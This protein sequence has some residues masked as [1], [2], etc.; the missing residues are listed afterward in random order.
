MSTYTSEPGT[1]LAGRYR[2]VDQVSTGVGWTFWKATDETLARAVT[3]LTFA[4]GFPR[5]TEA[6]TAARAASRLNDSRFAQVFDVEESDELAYVVSEW[7]TGETLVDLLA[8]GP[9]DPP[10]AT[11]IVG[12]AAHAL[13]AA[14]RSGQAHLRLDPSG[15]HWT[16]GGGVKIVGLG[17]DAALAGAELTGAETE[18]PALIDARDLGRLLYAALTG[19]WP[20]PPGTGTGALPPAPTDSDGEPCTPR[21]VTADVPASIDAFTCR[22]LF[23]QQNRQGPPLTSPAEFADALAAVAPRNQ[24]PPA[25]VFGPLTAQASGYRPADSA[26]SPYS[27]T[28]A[29]PRSGTFPGPR[30]QHGAPSAGYRRRH[31]D[32]ERSVVARSVVSAVIVLVLAAV[33]VTAWAISH[34]LHH[35]AT[36]PAQRHQQQ[37]SGPSAAAAVLLKPLSAAV[38]NPDDTSPGSDDPGEAQYALGGTA[39]RFWHTSYYFNYPQFGHLKKGAGLILDMGKRV[40]LSQIAVQ[41][42]KSCCTHATVEIGNSANPSDFGSFTS[43]ANSASAAGTT[44]FNVSSQASGRYVVIWITNLPPLTGNEYQTQIYDVTIHGTTV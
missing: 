44:T 40:K 33:G 7:V 11:S 5:V 1:R 43:L 24:V 2:L 28:D 18:T 9:L 32:S 20:G 39:G 6:V 34:S 42:G 41:F 37:T 27:F 23:Q 21:Q 8:E 38:Y 12:E 22:A 31:P 16:P 4:P 17:I 19:Y 14:H 26:T 15:L 25:S 3:V 10:R 29:G 30:A 35:T 36:P 13:A